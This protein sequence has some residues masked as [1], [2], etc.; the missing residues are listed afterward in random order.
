MTFSYSGIESAVQSSVY[1]VS[2]KK[3]N[4]EH[5]CSGFV[6]SEDGLIVTSA[7]CITEGNDHY[8]IS[9]E[10]GPIEF[11][12][13]KKLN[14]D[15]VAVFKTKE[16]E[17]KFKRYLKINYDHQYRYGEPVYTVGFPLHLPMAFRS[18]SFST[19]RD[20]YL[21]TDMNI[22]HGMSGAP[23]IS[24]ANEVI[25]VILGVDKKFDSISYSNSVKDLR[26]VMRSFNVKK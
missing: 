15:S 5:T 20:G 21:V 26:D 3:D 23:L 4:I 8:G 18:G 6:S 16:S 9:R 13:Y 19:I 22:H 7:H 24:S 10:K 1:I 14:E 12:D 17:G 25:G 2:M 11:S